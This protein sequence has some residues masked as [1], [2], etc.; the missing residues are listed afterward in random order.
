[1][2]KSDKI[3]EHVFLKVSIA[4]APP[5]TIVI[6]LFQKQ[7]PKTCANFVALLSCKE[8]KSTT[9]TTATTA[10]TSR[11]YPH[12]T[13]RGCEFHRII[14]KFMVQGGDF[15][16]FDGTGGYSPL[17]TTGTFNDESFAIS[18]NRAGIVSMANAGPNTNKSQFFITLQA[19]LHLDKKHVAFGQV[20]RG[21]DTVQTMTS[22]ELEHNDRPVSM[23]RIVISD[24]GI[25]FGNNDNERK[26]KDDDD[27][28]SVQEKERVKKKKKEKKISSKKSSKK[29]SKRRYSSSSSSSD[30]DSCDNEERLKKKRHKKKARDYT[31]SSSN[32][33]DDENSR[34]DQHRRRRQRRKKHKKRDRHHHRHYDDSSSSSSDDDDDRRKKK[35]HRSKSSSKN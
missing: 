22:V 4:G 12:P 1:M 32:I 20:T 35:K 2:N 11:K 3:P 8:T 10:T 30:D 33:S 29:N 18:H 24:C 5:Q 26:D 19:T 28:N 16:R 17:Y 14:D 31:S 21:M 25:G 15:E 23:Q 13:Y 27:N 34:E 6:Q 7:V 9:A